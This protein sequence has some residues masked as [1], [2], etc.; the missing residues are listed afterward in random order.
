VSFDLYPAT[1]EARKATIKQLVKDGCH[2]EVA[3]LLLQVVAELKHKEGRVF[4][5][6]SGSASVE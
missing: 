1:A 5:S 4:E 3:K 6:V 2:P